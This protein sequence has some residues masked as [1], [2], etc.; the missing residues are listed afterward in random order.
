MKI[1]LYEI[2]YYLAATLLVIMLLPDRPETSK[3]TD[4]SANMSPVSTA[5]NDPHRPADISE[6][7]REKDSQPARSFFIEKEIKKTE[8]NNEKKIK[9]LYP[10]ANRY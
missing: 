5:S 1:L 10:E 3:I 4:A 9:N 2:R 7:R 6:S 8:T